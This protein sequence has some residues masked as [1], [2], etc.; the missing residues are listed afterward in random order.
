MENL[1]AYKPK[2]QAITKF[3]FEN[4]IVVMLA[5]KKER[6]ASYHEL[7][8]QKEKY[9]CIVM[10]SKMTSKKKF[11]V[12]NFLVDYAIK[13]QKKPDCIY[14]DR[15]YELDDEIY[16]SKKMNIRIKRIDNVVKNAL[17]S[18]HY[19]KMKELLY[20]YGYDDFY[21]QY[22]SVK[23]NE[24]VDTVVS[25]MKRGL[26]KGTFDEYSY[27]EAIKNIIHIY[28]KEVDNKIN[29]ENPSF[30]DNM[31]FRYLHNYFSKYIVV[32]YDEELVKQFIMKYYVTEIQS[33][34][35]SYFFVIEFL[36]FYKMIRNTKFSW[37]NSYQ[38][39]LEDLLLY[40][41][42]RAGKIK[43]KSFYKCFDKIMEDD[44]N[45]Y[46]LMFLLELL[47]LRKSSSDKKEIINYISI[48]DLLLVENDRQISSQIQWKIIKLLPNRSYGK[49]ELSK[50]YNYRSKIIHGDYKKS[51]KILEELSEIE[52]Y[53]VTKE[54]LE[55]D[56]YS[57]KEQL[58]EKKV[59]KELY[60]LLTD[61]LR[62]F[63]FH[64]DKIRKIKKIFVEES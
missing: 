13:R 15:R 47:E 42:R 2:H 3:L 5:D 39:S 6:T 31:L 8:Y 35:L 44:E 30:N 38:F 18:Y 22:Q 14:I 11:G 28:Q 29:Y 64:N 21:K 32:D 60:K 45:Y 9:F 16:L 1:R 54:E 63:I 59:K 24:Y 41:S 25:K 7:D 48:L 12:I 37:K 17:I 62:L 36:L 4:K 58:I 19:C 61:I 55:F 56:I 34:D 53:K 46:N 57:N 33:E 49:I 10:D 23:D 26:I 27:I 43:Y 50:I 20:K 51:I 40:S 52:K